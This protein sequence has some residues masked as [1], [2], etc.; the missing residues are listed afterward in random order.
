MML[1]HLFAGLGLCAVLGLSIG[2]DAKKVDDAKKAIEKGGDK[3]KDETVKPI[4][5]A[6][7]KIQDKIKSMAGDAQVSAQSA[8]DGLKKLVEEFKASPSDKMKDLVKPLMEKFEALKK[9]VGM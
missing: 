7:P 6:M 4:E 2:C 5:E 8:F 9:S 3:L 1:R